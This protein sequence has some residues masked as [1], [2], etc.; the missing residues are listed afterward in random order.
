MNLGLQP[1]Q[2]NIFVAMGSNP[3]AN[4]IIGC[5][6]CELMGQVNRDFGVLLL[7]CQLLQHC[8]QDKYQVIPHPFMLGSIYTGCS[9][10]EQ[11]SCDALNY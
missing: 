11:S 4:H 9:F 6:D 10:L 2:E 8:W 7:P 3:V 5:A 1:G